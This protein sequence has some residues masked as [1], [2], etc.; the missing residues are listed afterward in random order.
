[1]FIFLYIPLWNKELDLKGRGGKGK[2]EKGRCV[3]PDALCLVRDHAFL[4]GVPFFLP[5]ARPGRE[6]KERKE[7]KE[8]KKKKEIVSFPER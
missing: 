6:E 8:E 3:A 7:K 5:P 1:M 4:G 2:K